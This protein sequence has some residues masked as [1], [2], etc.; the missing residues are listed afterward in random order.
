M[1]VDSEYSK[2]LEAIHLSIDNINQYNQKSK[3]KIQQKDFDTK[4]GEK[5]PTSSYDLMKP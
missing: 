1:I 3:N 2:R 4:D 5:Y